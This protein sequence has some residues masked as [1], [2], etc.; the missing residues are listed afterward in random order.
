MHTLSRQGIQVQGEDGGQ[1]LAFTGLHFRDTALVQHDAAQQLNGVGPLT[2][3]PVRG[4]PHG[5][6]GFGQNVVQGLTGFQAVL[7]LGGFALQFFLG[8]V[9]ISFLHGQDFVHDGLNLLDFPLGTGAEQF[10]EKSH[11]ILLCVF[12]WQ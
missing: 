3:N 7:E 6:E 4:F 8:K 11:S 5:G 9:F 1:G 2:Q 12:Q 10:I